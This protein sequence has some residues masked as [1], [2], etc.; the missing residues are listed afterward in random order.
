MFNH[1]RLLDSPTISIITVTF[2]ARQ[3]LPGLINSLRA[4]LNRNF[5]WIVVDGASTDATIDLLKSSSDIVSTWISEPDFGIYDALNKAIRLSTGEYYLVLGADDR[6]F[7][8]AIA[9]YRRHASISGAALV[10]ASIFQDG[11]VSTG[12]LGRSWWN[13][14]FAYISG[15]SVGT[16]IRRSLHDQF[17]YYSQRFPVAADMYFI[18]TVCMSPNVRIHRADFVAGDHGKQGVS[19]IDKAATFCDC[20]RIQLETERWKLL[21]IF[22][23]MAKLA[24]RSKALIRAA[25][26]HKAR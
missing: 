20:F 15:H 22:L 16:L 6:L 18:K 23:F 7:P 9:Q 25:T 8:D 12:K 4:Q 11:R 21:Q 10:T 24:L 17:G 5:E 1:Q 19:S 13:G 14:M 26:E 2:N 3:E